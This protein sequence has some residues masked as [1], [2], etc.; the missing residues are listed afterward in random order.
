[1]RVARRLLTGVVAG[2]VLTVLAVSA[3][4]GVQ[5]PAP[6]PPTP[7]APPA[8]ADLS[9][10]APRSAVAALD[11]LS[12]RFDERAAMDLVLFMD[13]FWRNAGNAGFNQSIDRIKARLEASGF[14]ARPAGPADGPSLWVEQSGKAP[15][16]DYTV[17]TL[18]LAADD[19]GSEEVLLS[20]QQQRVALCINS[21]STPDGGVV[22]PIVDV[23]AGASPADYDGKDIKGAVVV[24]D[25][26][27][28]RLWQ[29]AVVQRG[30]IGVVSPSMAGYIRPGSTAASQAKPRREWDVL[31]WGSIP[32]DE[33]RRAFGFKATP[34][35]VAQIRD[36][37]AR[38]PARVRVEIASTFAQAPIRALVAEIPGAVKPDE[39]VVLVA[40]IQEPGANDNATGCATLQ[41][42]AR[43]ILQGIREKT[44]PP[45]SRTLTFL[46]G[47][48]IRVSRQWMTDHPVEA[49][50]VRYMFSLDM[51]GEDIAKT[52][53]S[54]L[55]E[56][57]PDPSAAW[58]RPSDP[59]TEWGSRPVKADTLKGTLLNDLFLAVCQRRAR[60]TTWLVRTNPY[61]GGSDHSVFLGAGVPSLLAWHFV[62]WFYHAS[63]DRP[64]KTS[65]AEMKHVGV[66]IAATAL[67]LGG[68][69][70]ADAEDVVRLLE[71][72]AMARLTLE[73]QQGA[74]LIAAASDKPAAQATEAAVMA[75]W[76]KWYGEALRSVLALPTGGA[77]PGL[78]RRVSE[79]VE[80]VGRD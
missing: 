77:T 45:P 49:K 34:K 47:D 74:A 66:S 6:A 40:H 7:P 79:A 2:I 58:D 5:A 14:A 76:K 24:G 72:A 29:M 67:A 51:T 11:V 17:G 12:R 52:G 36:R 80:R 19:H 3:P 26:G 61:E 44:I 59:H 10:L 41:E 57:A 48:E 64:D 13:Q 56:K 32:Y 68:A 16:W 21:F 30:A 18:T 38:G 75:A 15:G 78:E 37:L 53:G 9:A 42:L 60:G 22:A 65:P 1:M 73:T 39:R 62:D 46:W 33:T 20:R 27:T 71:A 31:E 4:A 50:Q 55:I 43:A 28:G 25:A 63:L 8:P 35:A 54:F 70:T 23:G 69:T